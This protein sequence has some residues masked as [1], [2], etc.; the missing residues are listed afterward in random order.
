M[1]IRCACRLRG[2]VRKRC[3]LRH[4]RLLQ[5]NATHSNTLS[6]KLS[7]LTK[8][9]KPNLCLL[10]CALWAHVSRVDLLFSWHGERVCR[11]YTL[12]EYENASFQ[13]PTRCRVIWERCIY[14]EF[15]ILNGRSWMGSYVLCFTGVCVF[16]C[17]PG[18]FFSFKTAITANM[19][20]CVLQ[21]HTHT[22]SGSY[23]QWRL[24]S[25]FLL[26][27]ASHIVINFESRHRIMCSTIL[28]AQR[29]NNKCFMIWARE[30]GICAIDIEELF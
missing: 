26:Y 15:P 18:C 21:I 29:D 20:M 30:L 13:R 8:A 11:I 4:V 27:V 14:R 6:P 9:I 1:K 3:E 5:G 16:M 24:R 17:L 10:I 25:R 7:A 2:R 22:E 19:Y 12:F 28:C 23:G